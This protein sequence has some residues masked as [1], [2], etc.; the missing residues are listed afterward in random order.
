MVMI[1]HTQY[2][3]GDIFKPFIIVV[4]KDICLTILY[5]TLTNLSGT[6]LVGL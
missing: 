6:L 3:R 5:L 1:P 2:P 4:S